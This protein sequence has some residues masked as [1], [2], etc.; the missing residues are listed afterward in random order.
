MMESV[1]F[2]LNKEV[3]SRILH[4]LETAKPT[5]NDGANKNNT[6]RFMMFMKL[7]WNG[8]YDA[9]YRNMIPGCWSVSQVSMSLT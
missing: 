8:L 3:A 2:L 4:F 6:I 5:I 1:S 9:K 7:I